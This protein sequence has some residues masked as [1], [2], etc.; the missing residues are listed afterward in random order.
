M[1]AATAAAPRAQS[2]TGLFIAA[3]LSTFLFGCISTFWGLVV[4]TLEGSLGK[5]AVPNILLA[6][7]IGLV[8][9]SLLVGPVIDRLGKKVAL[10]GGML[11]VAAGV[12]G[13]GM[14]NSAEAA[15]AM[16]VMIGAGGSV[17]VTAANA[18]I[19]DISEL[20]GTWLNLINNAFAVGA[21]LGSIVIPGMIAGGFQKVAW[22]LAGIAGLA[23]L[24][25]LALP[26]PLPLAAGGGPRT[27]AGRLLGDPLLWALA[28][29]LFLY[30]G[31]EGTVWYWLNKYLIT[32]LKFDAGAAGRTLSLFPIGIIIGRAVC[33]WLLMRVDALKLTLVFSAAI[34]ITYTGILL[35]EDHN[36]VRLF[37]FLAGLAMAPLFPTILAATGAAFSQA[38]GTAMGLVITGG[39]LG[40][41]AIPPSIGRVS[42]L[43]TG[44]FLTTGAAVVMILTNVVALRLA[45]RRAAVP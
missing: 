1:P 36:A 4:P 44:L 27:S 3:F 13:L 31:C 8:L 11:L 24:F 7:S 43:H 34:A 38:T 26:F 33:S 5:E 22:G 6:N 2:T 12:A 30:V 40:Y 14:I 10:A 19:S 28:V 35:V 45:A 39:W 25:F 9:G 37:V 42:E 20:R 16:A 21:T 23:L 29:M 32:N 15:I 18:L 41:V 17:I